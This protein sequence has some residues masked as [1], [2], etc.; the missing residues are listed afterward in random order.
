MSSKE[1]RP[2]EAQEKHD[3]ESTIKRN[4]HGDFSK[5]Q[6]SRQDWEESSH[7][8]YTK[9]KNPNWNY[10]EGANDKSG[11]SKSHVSID[12]YAEGRQPVSNYKLLISG[13][14]PRP[15]GFLST[16]SK[17][18]KSTNLA[19]FSYT[20]MFNH[21][22]P[23]FGVG[24]SGG[25][26]NEK[27]TL[28]N[29]VDSGEYV[30]NIISEDYVEA[31]NACAIDLPYGQSEWSVSGLTPEDSKV[32][33]ASRVKEAVFSVEGKL[34]STQEFESRATPGK[35]TGVLAIIEG[36]HFWAREDAINEDR[37]L[38]APEILR[39]IARL[40]GITYARVTQGF[41]I[42]RPVLKQEKEQGK[43]SDELIMP[44]VDGQP[45]SRKDPLASIMD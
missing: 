30:I 7:W 11:Q 12:P 42:P 15:I 41:E 24:F 6:A 28:K 19:P 45:G 26:D 16:K 25:F 34:L 22:P 21:D 36:V 44:K 32:V 35:K 14:I 43:I 27:D 39:P 10:G 23:I 3:A 1:S 8:H 31:A 29:L 18:G 13:I 40:G 38:I 5:V 9:T 37:S 20:Q 4:P 33:A 2:Q 17:D